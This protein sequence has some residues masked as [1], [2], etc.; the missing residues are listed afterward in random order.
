MALNTFIC[1]H[2]MPLYFKGLIDTC[3]VAD[4]HC[5]FCEMLAVEQFLSRSLKVINSDSV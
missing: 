3:V 1:N 5:V 4:M 2:L